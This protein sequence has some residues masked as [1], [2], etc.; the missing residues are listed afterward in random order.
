MCAIAADTRARLRY[1][2][3]PIDRLAAHFAM[4]HKVQAGT[5]PAHRRVPHKSAEDLQTATIWRGS[6]FESGTPVRYAPRAFRPARAAKPSR[7][8]SVYSLARPLL[9]LLDAEQF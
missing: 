9:F 6:A 8:H 5:R 7:I 3:R 2:A 4:L 1:T